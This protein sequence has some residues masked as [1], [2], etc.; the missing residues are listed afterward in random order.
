MFVMAVPLLVTF[1]TVSYIIAGTV[2]PFC[3]DEF[4]TEV[5]LSSL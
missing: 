3:I 2:D 1:D 5:V 4:V